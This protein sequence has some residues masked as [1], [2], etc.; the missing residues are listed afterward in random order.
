MGVSSVVYRRQCDATRYVANKIALVAWST[1]C[2]FD[3]TFSH[4]FACTQGV[5]D[6]QMC[7]IRS[8][9]QATL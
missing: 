5:V 4:R 9:D 3:Q 2:L 7:R 8:N 6:M 1:A